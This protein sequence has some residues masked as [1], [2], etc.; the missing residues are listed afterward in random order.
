MGKN[1]V[2]ACSKLF[3]RLSSKSTDGQSLLWQIFCKKKPIPNRDMQ[4]LW[5]TQAK[6]PCGKLSGKPFS[7]FADSII[8]R[9]SRYLGADF[10][11]PSSQ[12]HFLGE[13]VSKKIYWR[14]N[15]QLANL[16][17]IKS[18]RMMSRDGGIPSGADEEV[19]KRHVLLNTKY[20]FADQLVSH[21]LVLLHYSRIVQL[22]IKTSFWNSCFFHSQHT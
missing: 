6:P 18:T 7:C 17:N 2:E 12:F 1:G 10:S 21:T 16:K 8:I 5:Q 11:T 4:K 20:C 14:A 22:E 3:C 13:N 15:Y 9:I 19:Y